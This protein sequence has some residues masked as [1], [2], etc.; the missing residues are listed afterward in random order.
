MRHIIT[1]AMSARLGV[2]PDG[3]AAH[4]CGNRGQAEVNNSVN[5]MRRPLQGAHPAGVRL[6]PCEYVKRDG[7]CGRNCF[8]GRCFQ[9]KHS[10]NH[11][12][13]LTCGQA[14]RSQCRYCRKC[15]EGTAGVQ[16]TVMKQRLR[17]RKKLEAEWDA[18]I[19]EIAC[20]FGKS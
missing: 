11:V 18:Y 1:R 6:G 19:D 13:C 3:G 20:D 9:H 2:L 5:T 8:D 15:S 4:G 7:L 12:P 10:T 14:T 16:G 17:C